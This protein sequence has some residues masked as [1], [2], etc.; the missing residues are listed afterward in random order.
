MR[1]HMFNHNTIPRFALPYECGDLLAAAAALLRNQI[2]SPDPF[3]TLLGK[4]DKFWTSSGRQALWLALKALDLKPRSGV[5][6]P[7]F[8][9]LSVSTAVAEA[10]CRP[11]FI[12]ITERTLT[13]DPGSLATARGQF[14]AVV[15]VH[16]FGQVADIERIREAAGPVPL[17]EDTV[18]APL[19]R[20]NNKDV[21]EFGFACFHSFAS[22]KY[23]PAG[24]GGLLVVRDS[25]IAQR[26]AEEVRLLRRQSPAS[27]WN[28]LLLQLAK[29]IT[30]SR[31]LYRILG[32]PLRPWAEKRAFLEPVLSRSQI[33]RHQAAVALR[34]ALRFRERVAQQRENSLYLLSLL[35]EAEGVV[36]PRE[37]SGATYNYHLFPVLMADEEERSN[38]AA[39][40]LTHGVDSSRIY[41][42][43]IRHSRSLGYQGGC[44]VSES[45]A[46]R[47]LTL[48]NYASLSRAD[49]ERVA[50][51]FLQAL[52]QCRPHSRGR[53]L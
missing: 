43:V 38:V 42:G 27:E 35:R 11:I 49:I 10:G 51:A 39:A 21:G 16:L 53:S 25:E 41:S 45:V 40:M 36:L 34:Q 17:V 12:D 44:P 19:S 50:R 18:H 24:G 2:S 29:A 23:W 46:T 3:S 22:T 33:Q 7:L 9:D 1:T 26:V 20:L 14:S 31:P 47:L 13:M 30:F 52:R 32:L 8:N 15:A 5:A 37:W 28:N 6:V 4:G 48:P